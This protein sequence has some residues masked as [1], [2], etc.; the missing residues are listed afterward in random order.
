MTDHI[1]TLNAAIAYARRGWPVVPVPFRKKGP[2]LRGWQRLRLTEADLPQHFNSQPMNIGVLLGEP[3]GLIDVDLDAPEA[4][5]LAPSLLLPTGCI[6]GRK[7][8]PASHRL[9]TGSINGQAT[10]KFTGP[11]GDCLVELRC[12]G[13][14]TIFPGSVHPSGEPVEWE[15][16]DE[17]QHVDVVQL[18]AA[19]RELAAACLLLRRY[20]VQGSRHDFA[21]GLAGGLIRAGW[22]VLKVE[23]Y[24][25]VI[26]E[27]AGDDE[28]E[29]RVRV[30]ADTKAAIDASESVTGWP[31]VSEIID[32]VGPKEQY[33]ARIR[34]HLNMDRK[35]TPDNSA[36]AL[37]TTKTETEPDDRLRV[38][39]LSEVTPQEIEWLWDRRFPL[40]KFSLVAGT[41]GLGKSFFVLDMTARISR[42][43]SWPDTPDVENPKGSVI[44]LSAEDAW[45]DTVVPRLNWAGADLSRV[46]AIDGVAEVDHSGDRLFDI[47][48]DL[49]RLE[50]LLDDLGDARLIVLDPLDS[51][52]GE[53]VNPNKTT[54]VRRVLQPLIKLAEEHNVAVIGVAHLNKGADLSAL[55][56]VLGS[57]AYTSIARA[58]W[59]IAKDPDDPLRRLL[60]KLKFNLAIAAPNVA[61]SLERGQVLWHPGTVDIDADE[62]LRSKG[63]DDDNAPTRI[64]EAVTFLRQ[65]LSRGSQRSTE[66][67]RW[68]KENDIAPST[69]KRAK[70][71]LGVESEA[72]WS[73]DKTVWYVSLPEEGELTTDTL[74]DPHGP[75]GPDGPDGRVDHIDHIDHQRGSGGQTVQT[76][77]SG[78]T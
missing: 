50:T 59:L 10:L 42:G 1:P 38:I 66:V 22:S 70:A 71:K 63:D 3:S 33:T 78:A 76:V 73:G 56:R 6:F 53:N 43:T 51:Y 11:S 62:A 74:T 54:D 65:A 7:S 34:R 13:G 18:L 40:G 72:K 49:P 28:V 48:R 41:Q 35:Q 21:L 60:L 36:Q 58:S 19:V 52:L 77:E 69:L 24:I 15:L 26:A 9:Y 30:V 2:T 32:G 46:K 64:D 16:D 12:T 55:Y 61:F 67:Q 17:P 14:Q 45:A 44:L 37:P 31:S 23:H 57:V 68:A 5:K 25:E 8:K 39:D 75:D 20:P 47:Q 27:A 4:V 29:D